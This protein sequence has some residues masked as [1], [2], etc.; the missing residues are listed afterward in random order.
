MRM[1]LDAIGMAM[2]L[3]F[4]WLALAVGSVWEDEVRCS[5]GYTEACLALDNS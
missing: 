3:V 5:R 2:F 4:M 1:I